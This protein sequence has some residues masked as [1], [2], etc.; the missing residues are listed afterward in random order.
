MKIM[1]YIN[2]LGYN[3]NSWHRPPPD[4]TGINF[5]SFKNKD[6]Q[7]IWIGKKHYFQ[8]KISKILKV[9]NFRSY[10]LFSKHNIYSKPSTTT[11]ISTY[12]LRNIVCFKIK[13]CSNKKLEVA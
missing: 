10:P 6:Y 4:P 12:V 2:S 13:F 8:S 1:Q 9:I 11:G 3:N 7:R 5:Y